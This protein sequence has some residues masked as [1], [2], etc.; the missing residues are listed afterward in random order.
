MGWESQI[1]SSLNKG[2][3]KDKNN[4]LNQINLWIKNPELEDAL[5]QDQWTKLMQS[6]LGS[7]LSDSE[8]RFHQ[9]LSK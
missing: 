1:I 9:K 3:V 5:T 8:F 7:W 2:K 6:K 4:A